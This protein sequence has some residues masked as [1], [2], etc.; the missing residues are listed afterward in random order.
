[1][2]NI[3]GGLIERYKNIRSRAKLLDRCVNEYAFVGYGGHSVD[4]L[5]PVLDYLNVPLKYICCRSKEKAGLIGKKYSGITTTTDLE[6]ILSDDSVKGVF[7]SA[8]PSAHFEIAS[9]VLEARKALFVEKPPCRTLEELDVLA[10]LAVQRE[11]VAVVGMQ[12]RYSPVT[13]A[14][15]RA[16]RKDAA[17][18]YSLRYVTGRYP[19]GDPLTDL[20][21]HPLDYVSSIFGDAVVQGFETVRTTGGGVTMMLILRHRCVSGIL[22]LSTSASWEGAEE[23]LTVRS[24]KGTYDM[25]GMEALTFRPHC[26]TFMGVPLEKV[27]RH[28]S[29]SVDLFSR[30]S[31]IPVLVN[32]QIYT[33]GYYSEI[34][35]FVDAV[36]GCEVKL[37][38]TI[39]ALRPTYQLIDELRARL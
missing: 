9:R 20:F 4:N 25:R 35:A 27:F 31:F 5:Y 13:Q 32:N 28:P 21:I 6:T 26:G 3:V 37:F 38:S 29:V 8:S 17:E 12:K 14:L 39:P 11:V 23:S 34:K 10:E 15:M 18:S 19:E 2:G 22:E 24:A 36:E 7:V 1:M 30:N 16:L 33:Q